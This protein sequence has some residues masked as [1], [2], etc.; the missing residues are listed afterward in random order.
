MENEIDFLIQRMID[1][2][3][4]EAYKYADQL[5]EIGTDEAMEKAISILENE[6]MESA[7][8]AARAL[9]KMK[10]NNKALGPLLEVIHDKKNKKNTGA[11]VE[12]LEAFDLSENFVDILR[13]YLFGSY[14]ASALAKEYLDHSE[15]DITPRVIKKAEKHWRHYQSN[16]K[17]DDVFE[18]KKK[19]VE[20]IL[21]DLRSL[22]EGE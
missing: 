9:G 13:I 6:D 22:F 4:Q 15:F 12:V 14:K 11:L 20:N 8:L 18:L 7:Y 16:T 17:K 10:H 2:N 19:E 5:G 21:N 1:K 3:E